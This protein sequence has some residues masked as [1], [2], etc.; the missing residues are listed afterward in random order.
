MSRNTGALRTCVAGCRY[1][2]WCTWRDTG[3][4]LPE[5]FPVVAPSHSPGPA[6]IRRSRTNN[7]AKDERPEFLGRQDADGSRLSVVDRQ[8]ITYIP[9]RRGFMYLFAVLDG[10]VAGCWPGGSPTR[11]QPISLSMRCRRRLLGM[12]S[13]PSSIPTKCQ[14]S[15]LVFTWLLT[16]HGIQISMDGKGAGETTCSSNDCGKH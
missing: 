16:H 5:R 2:C 8:A 12:A 15:S 11:S 1:P 6:L 10:Q 14:F 9:M 4:V 3:S 13:R 7:G